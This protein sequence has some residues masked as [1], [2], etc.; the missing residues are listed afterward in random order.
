[1][2][3]FSQKARGLLLAGIACGAAAGAF[4]QKVFTGK[5]HETFDSPEGWALKYF[6]SAT[7][8]SGLQPPDM[9]GEH[10]QFGSVNLGFESDWLPELNAERA[11]VGFSGHKQEDLNKVPVVLR[12]VLR[13]GL[14]WQFTAFAAAP[15]PW[16]AFGVTPRLVAFGLE[17]PLVRR[18][19]WTLGWRAS[20]QVGSVKAAF[21]CPQQVLGFPAGSPEN[22]SGCVG[23]SAD[24]ASLRYGG[25]EI[26]AAARI[27]KVRRLT[28]HVAL[29]YNYINSSFQ[30]N[31]P[32]K[33]GLDRT[34]LWTAGNTVTG[35][36]GA[37][38]LLTN[39][40]ALTVDAFYTPL[41]IRRD[42]VGGRV[43]DGLFNVRALVSYTLR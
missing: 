3:R 25:T 20:G 36:A 13:V 40:M 19:R 37:S 15:P 28:P 23:L 21:T 24:T 38:Y 9:P 29:G 27:P 6:T 5:V 14:P 42:N 41:F 7:I 33:Q 30:L 31:A 43:N 16:E 4:A 2:I 32:I 18:E 17:R 1:M 12:P 10:R 22:P 8:M 26:Q 35:S 11:R 34:F 39:R